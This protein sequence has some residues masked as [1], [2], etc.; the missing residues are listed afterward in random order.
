MSEL[1][2]ALI[3]CGFFAVNQMHGWAG[4]DGVSIAA[5]CDRDETRL[6]DMGE[7]FGIERRFT[8]ARAMLEEVGPDF[9]DIATTA[10]S[11]RALVELAASLKIPVICQKPFAPSMDDARAMVAACAKAG[12]PLMVHENFRW[13]SP[14]QA[15]GKILKDGA[16]GKAFFGRVSFRSAYDVY[17]GQPYLAE[18][19]RFIIEDLGIHALDIARFLFGDVSAITARTARINPRIRGEDV[20]TMLLA[21]EGATSVV[22]CSYATK[23]EEELFPQ[24]LIEI[25]GTE[26]S[27]RLGANYRLTV[28]NGEGTRH[29]DVSPP[30]LP[31]A[32]RP[33]HN[34]QESVAAIQ[35]HWV[36]CLAAGTEPETSGADN[37]KTLA[38]VEAAYASAADGGGTLDPNGF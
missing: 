30:L 3:G 34:I 10:P 23:L 33:W 26:G 25:D 21:H 24:T 17:S 6:R 2:G 18:G 7:R 38:L 20:A 1:K 28:T 8:D 36:R 14:I 19:N 9:V 29:E 37:L 22:D 12:V 4:I 31:W 13:Q 27:I 15:V 32:E 5:I 16:I 35:E 11:H